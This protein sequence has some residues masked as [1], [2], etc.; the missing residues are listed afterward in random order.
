[1]KWLWTYLRR[2]V[3]DA[4]LAGVHDAFATGTGTSGLTDEQAADAL[5][6]LIGISADDG[7]TDAAAMLEQSAD[8]DGN[9]TA[10][11]SDVPKRGPGR[12]RKLEPRKYQE[13]PQ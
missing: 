10:P 9:G 13:P 6:D 12:P 8:P 4:L 2:K 7:E 11:L 1:M 5:R 3:A